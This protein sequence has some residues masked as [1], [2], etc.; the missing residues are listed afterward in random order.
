MFGFL[1]FL[2]VETRPDIAFATL[3]AS[4]FSKNLSYQY[5]EIVKTILKY[6]K[7]SKVQGICIGRLL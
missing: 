4:R 6:L 5:T 2:I 7:G 1:I 3:L